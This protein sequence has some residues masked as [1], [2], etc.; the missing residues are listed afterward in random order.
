VLEL[1]PASLEQRDALG[2]LEMSAERD[3]QCEAPVVA[4]VGV[5]EQLVEPH[6][7]ALG[8]AVDL[9]AA[10]APDVAHPGPERCQLT[11]ERTARRR[12]QRGGVVLDRLDETGLL[13]PGEGRIQRSERD[14]GTR[15]EQVR[16]L[17]LQLVAVQLLLLEQPEDGE[18]DHGFS[19]KI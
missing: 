12:A 5:D 9:L 17:L 11:C 10:A 19:L 2:G 15:P 7:A 14:G 1:G 8:D 13:E 6:V 4:H 16:E 18:V 3:A